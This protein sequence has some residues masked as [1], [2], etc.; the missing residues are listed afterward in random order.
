MAVC[1]ASHCLLVA[2][3][4]SIRFHARSNKHIKSCKTQCFVTPIRQ[5]SFWRKDEKQKFAELTL[6]VLFVFD[7]G[8][9]RNA[10]VISI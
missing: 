5:T 8:N 1:K 3:L 9:N 4:S 7:Y 6:S 10:T 2:Q